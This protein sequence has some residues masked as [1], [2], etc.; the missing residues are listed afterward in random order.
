MNRLINAH[1]KP[2]VSIG[3]V[4]LDRNAQALVGFDPIES[5]SLQ[6]QLERRYRSG[7]LTVKQSISCA[8]SGLLGG[9]SWQV[10]CG[11]TR[12]MIIFRQK[13]AVGSRWNS[14]LAVVSGV[15]L[16]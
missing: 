2:F 6:A 4:G 5:G 9:R 3:R 14:N 12:V 15:F 16:W 13:Y 11:F 7:G 1:V 10:E 8:I